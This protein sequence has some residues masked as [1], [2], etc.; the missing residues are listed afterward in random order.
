MTVRDSLTTT[1]TSGP[2]LSAYG[3]LTAAWV[4]AG[5]SSS[6]TDPASLARLVAT[7]VTSH[8]RSLSQRLWR[9]LG[10]D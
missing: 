9:Y 5:V 7:A 1:L 6:R 2:R 3:T 4:T 10:R 8:P